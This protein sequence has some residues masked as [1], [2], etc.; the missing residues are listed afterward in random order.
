MMIKMNKH[1]YC[2]VFNFERIFISTSQIRL[3]AILL[4]FSNEL[5]KEIFRKDRG[6]THA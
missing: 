1:M 6:G 4:L 5:H 2:K 3:H